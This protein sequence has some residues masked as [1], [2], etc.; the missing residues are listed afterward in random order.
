MVTKKRLL[1]MEGNWKL[2][3]HLLFHTKRFGVN[4]EWWS[5]FD[6]WVFGKPTSQIIWDIIKIYPIIKN[7]RGMK[8]R[9]GVLHFMTDEQYELAFGKT[10]K[11]DWN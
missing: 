5:S 6:S 3:V 10:K 11:Q 1:F 8:F 4:N 7:Y 2:G 9:A